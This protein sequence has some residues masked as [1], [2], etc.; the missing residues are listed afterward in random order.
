[1]TVKAGTVEDWTILNYAQ[2]THMFHIHQIHFLV[3][4]AQD[5]EFGLGQMLDM[6]NVPYGVFKKPGDTSGNDMI[7]GAVTLRM[8]FRDKDIIGEFPFHCHIL[9]HE[10]GGMM[11][12]VRVIP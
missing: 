9:A 8:D 6:V 3:L 10:D 2:E 12:M 1:V 5:Y 7:P 4:K 11:A